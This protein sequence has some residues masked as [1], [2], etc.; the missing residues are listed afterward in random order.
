MYRFRSAL[1]KKLRSPLPTVVSFTLVLIGLIVIEETINC[2]DYE[3]GLGCRMTPMIN[4]I[5]F[6]YVCLFS[7]LVRLFGKYI[8]LL[9]T[10]AAI[11]I[12]WEMTFG[13]LS[14][15]PLSWFYLFMIVHVALSYI[16]VLALPM[17]LVNKKINAD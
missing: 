7:V 1:S 14:V 13:G 9:A 3:D 2:I 11:G 10:A 4:I 5:L 15:L 16:F 6:G 8:F 17:Y 12:L